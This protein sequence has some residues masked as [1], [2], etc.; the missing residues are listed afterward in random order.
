MPLANLG[1]SHDLAKRIADLEAKVRSLSSPG[2]QPP[3][4]LPATTDPYQNAG[5]VTITATTATGAFLAYFPYTHPAVAFAAWAAVPVGTVATL[6]MASGPI[7]GSGMQ[8][9]TS[10]TWTV[11]GSVEAVQEPHYAGYPY[12][13]QS[14][15]AFDLGGVPGDYGTAWGISL[16]AQVNVGSVTVWPPCI[17]GVSTT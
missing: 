9:R 7:S 5:T 13:L 6:T 15:P 2:L 10:T 14:N 1:P 17:V 3:T 12:T 11:D 16:Q 8:V 4:G